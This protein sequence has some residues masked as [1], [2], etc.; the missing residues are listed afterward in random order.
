MQPITTLKKNI[1]RSSALAL[2]GLVLTAS[3]AKASV[4]FNAG[5]LLFG[6][7]DTTGGISNVYLFDVGA[8]PTSGKIA[9]SSTTLNSDLTSLFGSDWATN[10][11]L[12]WGVFGYTNTNTLEVGKTEAT[13]GTQ[14]ATY[15][16]AG[17]SSA[18]R[19]TIV[20]KFNNVANA[21]P[22]PTGQYVNGSTNDSP[23][24]TTGG[25]SAGGGVAVDKSASSGY[26]SFM[27]SWSGTLNGFEATGF[28]NS[29]VDMFTING[30]SAAGNPYGGS[31]YLDGTGNLVF[32]TTT[33]STV[34]EPGRVALI[35]LGMA[36]LLLRRRRSQPLAA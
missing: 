9:I 5:D 18:G 32:S 30:T 33:P 28:T 19:N 13:Y 14:V 12:G 11:N 21:L 31:Y 1:L 26:A 25:T 15:S 4:T 36:G 23:T 2:A 17:F 27:P 34:P 24:F 16:G 8:L 35:G 29:A 6:V 20:G 3:P 10:A 22:S 7:R